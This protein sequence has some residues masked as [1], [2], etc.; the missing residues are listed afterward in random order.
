MKLYLSWLKL[1]QL[2]L[3][4][5]CLA[6]TDPRIER[7]IQGIKRDHNEP[8]RRI[9]TPLTRPYLLYIFCLLPG[10]DYDNTTLAA[11][12]TMAFA[13]FVRIGEFTYR[14]TDR[15]L[16]ASFSKLFLTKQCLHIPARESDMEL[17]IPASKTDPFRNGITLTIA[18]SGSA[19]CPVHGMRRLQASDHHRP[20]SAP[21]FCI[22]RHQQLAFTR[23]HV[24]RRV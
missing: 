14:E 5:E 8:E 24:V 20:P 17:T 12:F 23:E 6:F 10:P 16:E 19:A 11:A 1:Y 21:L 7:T 15:E 22:G 18:T 3:R 13:G 4:I 9:R 2:D